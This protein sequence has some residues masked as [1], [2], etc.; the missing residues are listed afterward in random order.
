[1]QNPQSCNNQTKGY[2]GI[3]P[4]PGPGTIFNVGV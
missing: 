2:N 1:M 4:G 3:T